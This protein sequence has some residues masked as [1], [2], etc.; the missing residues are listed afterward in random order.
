MLLSVW[1]MYGLWEYSVFIWSKT[2]HTPIIRVDLLLI[3]P[4]MFVVTAI[5]V[6]KLIRNTNR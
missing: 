5:V 3:Y 4:F 2:E 6:Y 1:V